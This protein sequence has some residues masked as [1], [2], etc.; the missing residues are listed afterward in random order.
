MF[1]SNLNLD[2]TFYLLCLWALLSH[3]LWSI[4]NDF[5]LTALLFFIRMVD[6]S[7][8]VYYYYADIT[9]HYNWPRPT[10]INQIYSHKTLICT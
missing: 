1:N 4:M 9:D 3:P 6:C 5:K 10:W 8:R 7:I 2:P